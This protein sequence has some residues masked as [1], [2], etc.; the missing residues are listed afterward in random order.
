MGRTTINDVAEKA[1]VS[2]S[3]I[4]NFL[5]DRYNTMSEKTRK[6]IE[7]AI[8]ELNY[9]P[10][11][12]AQVISKKDPNKNICII[13]PRDMD[14]ILNTSFFRRALNGINKFVKKNDFRTMIINPNKREKEDLIYIKSLSQGLI[15]GFI[16]FEI[17]INDAF[18]DELIRDNIPFMVV[19]KYSDDKGANYVDID[20]TGAV[21]TI[22]DHLIDKHGYEKIALL[23][24]FEKMIVCNQEV[25]GYSIALKKHNLEVKQ[26]YI[27][28]GAANFENGY[29]HMKELLE[30]KN[31]PNAVISIIERIPGVVQAINETGLKVPDDIAIIGICSDFNPYKFDFDLSCIKIPAYE[32][33]CEAT[34]YLMRMIYSDQQNN[35]Y[36]KIIKPEFIYTESC[37]C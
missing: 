2:K 14:Y 12:G 7:K 5:N 37:G 6:N 16:L 24:V 26:Q 27:K 21:E 18:I 25:E 3:T 11:I 30:L 36:K 35:D 32:I 9:S 15:D 13:I 19:G 28:K 33:G 1:G 34:K 17:E 29:N 8:Q 10:N 20:Y 31:P 23:T 22:T 4:S